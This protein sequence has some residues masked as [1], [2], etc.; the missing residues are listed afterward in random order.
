VPLRRQ[1]CGAFRG[2]SGPHLVNNAVGFDHR[3]VKCV[4]KCLVFS[5][6]LK[7]MRNFTGKN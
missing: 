4:E 6:V 3:P 2:A 7:S 5:M 1:R